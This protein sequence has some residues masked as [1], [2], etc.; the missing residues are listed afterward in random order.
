MPEVNI[1]VKFDKTQYENTPLEALLKLPSAKYIDVSSLKLTEKKTGKELPCQAV[2]LADSVYKIYWIENEAKP[3]EE[4][5][6]TLA[7]EYSDKPSL[8]A[9]GACKILETSECL[10]VR[11]EDKLF[12]KYVYNKEGYKPYLYPILGPVDKS[13]TQLAPEDHPHHK[14]IWVAFG[15]VNGYDFWAEKE[16]CGKI[17]HEEVLKISEGPVL[18]YIETKSKWIT[19]EGTP[20]LQDYRTIKAYNL[21]PEARIL[22][23]TIMLKALQDIVVF[24]DTKEGGI[25][26]TRVADEI[27]VKDGGKIVDSEGRE[28]EKN[29]W[30]KRADWCDY[31]GIIDGVTAGYAIFDYPDNI[32]HP[33]HWHVRDYG[34]FCP[35]ISSRFPD[36][37]GCYEL[38]KDETLKLK[39]R[40]YIHRGNYIEA[41]VSQKYL[42]YALPVK[43]L[44]GKVK[45]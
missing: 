3:N 16:G 43:I 29:V 6:Y 23:I 32:R 12:T 18:A 33:C 7:F 27:D 14:S 41:K 39:Y 28:Y 2:Y 13:L 19:P 36:F 11:I 4:K 42:E 9:P 38:Q 45:K 25:F 21:P 44:I 8:K 35:N 20:L 24:Y 5:H 30:G 1:I 15:D 40:I 31:Y 37:P 10:E 22:D 17:V 34:M 26:A